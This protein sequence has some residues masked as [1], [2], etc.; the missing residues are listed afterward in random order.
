MTLSKENQTAEDK[1]VSESFIIVSRDTR[2]G[3][4][5][6][7]IENLTV[8][9]PDN[10]GTTLLNN[11]T[12]TIK[13]GEVIILTGESGAGKTTA[14]KAL[15]GKWD[16]GS[17]HISIP[18][19]FKVR[20]ISQH[21]KLP[22]AT[23][24]G[25]LNLTP[26]G[27]YIFTDRQLRDALIKVGLPQLVQ[28]VPGQ[29]AEILLDSLVT[30]ARSLLA[31]GAGMAELEENL[32][33]RAEALAKEQFE[34]A[35]S[36]PEAQRMNFAEQL[37]GVLS[38]ALADNAPRPEATAALAGKIVDRIDAT[39]ARIVTN[40]L[41]HAVQQA[42][43]YNARG[44]IFWPRL[45][46]TADKAAY[47]NW[48]V[49]QSLDSQLGRYLK[50]KDTE[51]PS[52][53]IRL[54]DAQKT[55]IVR[56]LAAGVQSEVNTKYVS[57]GVLSTAFNLVAWPLHL[58]TLRVRASRTAKE[59]T[60]S[61]SFFMDRQVLKGDTLAR[62][63]SGGQLKKL[64]AARALLHKPDLLVMDEITTGVDDGSK[65]GIYKEILD[66]LPKE[67]TVISILHDLELTDLHTMHA[68]LENKTL[69]F[70]KVDAADPAVRLCPTCPQRPKGP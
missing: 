49:K 11:L 59:L 34:Y 26:T 37:A 66:A 63:L 50:N 33:A 39:L 8:K 61:L 29:Q 30:D 17:G 21:I 24:R 42:A 51:D 6:I 31:T 38:D 22:N 40:G 15:L 60:Q 46:M 65:R 45:S 25:I 69:T 19:N 14:V 53:E 56:E 54:N 44:K 10:K 18:E 13:Q 32:T 35:Q 41:Q 62:Q 43:H 3:A 67:T 1:P 27:Q 57:K 52:R 70:T 28:H 5:D 4:K 16:T 64:M 12:T 20:A 55:Q 36:V 2:P 47:F 58:L 23:M 48:C 68:R 9:L 7:E